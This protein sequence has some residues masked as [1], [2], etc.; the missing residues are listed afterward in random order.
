MRTTTPLTDGWEISTTDDGDGG[1][2][3][4]WQPVT[5]PHCTNPTDPIDVG[6]DHRGPAWYRRTIDVGR[7]DGRR[8]VLHVGA[9][10][11]V[12]D[13]SVDGTALAQHRGAYSAF[14]VDLTDA[15]DAEG[16]GTV[17]IRTD[18]SPTDDVYPLMGDHTMFGGL[19]REVELIE[20]DPVHIDVAHHA[21]PGV[22]VEQTHLDDDSA[23]L[24]VTVRVANDGAEPFDGPVTVTVLDAEGAPVATAEVAA[25][26]D[27]GQVRDVDLSIDIDRPRRWD[28][29]RDPYLYRLV[30]EVADD[31]VEQ[32]V[33]LRT[34]DID[35]D[36][37]V[38]LNG[39]PYR[40][41]GVSRHHDV[42][43][44]PAVSRA[45]IERDI[46][47]IDEIGATAVRLAHYQHAEH[48][49]DLCDEHGL[50]VWAE[51]PLNAK[52]S[53][54]DPVTNAASQLTELI[55]QQRHHPSIV[56][57][58]VQNETLISE[59][60][61]DPR[62]VIAEL[63]A[64]A[65]EL[66]PSRRTAQAQVFMAGPEDPINSL[67]DLNARN[68]YAG[69]YYGRAEQAGDDLDRHHAA[70]PGV[71]LGL[72]EYGADART[73]YHATDPEP[74]DYTEDYQAAMHEVY[75]RLIDE[76]PWIWSSFVWN[77]F[78]FA[79]AIRNEGGTKGFN[80]KGLVTRDRSV[81]KDA[82]W[83]YKANWSD[84][85]VLHICSR[86]FVNRVD[87]EIDVKVYANVGPVEL[88]VD[89][90]PVG[91]PVVDGVIHRWRIRLGDGDTRVVA[92]SGEL[93]DEATFR[94]VDDADP[95]Y[96][97]P[98][99]RRSAGGGGT[100][101]SWFEDS[102][103]EV[104]HSRFGTWS[105]VG[106]LLDDPAANAV[107]EETFGSAFRDHPMLDTARGISLAIVLDIAGVKMTDE[108]VQAL[109]DRLYAL[110]RPT[111]DGD[112]DGSGSG[113]GAGRP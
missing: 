21:G 72:S 87:P 93:T 52:V 51:I 75:W 105:T 76:R 48:V 97:C 24:A 71:P 79:S 85:P 66:D 22:V 65:R 25:T 86:R 32:P 37:G 77:M 45:D 90:D 12:A 91:E 13:V 31:R 23:R 28:G 62:P 50:V 36:A 55:V 11:V 95:A 20:L 56:C 98:D 92:R 80:M 73:E 54:S 9:A 100:V 104:D 35:A 64:L 27:A 19:Y 70:N 42:N 4:P 5:L 74:G 96:V 39:R 68:L 41:Y 78:D 103:L 2:A 58:G 26:V 101:T 81:R 17:T 88:L 111:G 94:R 40:L 107:I 7:R 10:G 82:F 1:A 63:H 60:S 67:C 49:L 53:G 102:G 43:G 44:T 57:W 29:R 16:R 33:G 69:W 59:S 112:G 99:P 108:D 109:H 47:L 38:R 15:L 83:W 3:G 113:D 18:N 110:E 61:A 6:D 34:F 89:G 106:D 14:R 46:D 30:A 8:V 84:E